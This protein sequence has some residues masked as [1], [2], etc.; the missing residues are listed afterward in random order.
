MNDSL[1]KNPRDISSNSD[2]HNYLLYK[3]DR[4]VIRIPYMVIAERIAVPNKRI[5]GRNK[6]MQV[7]KGIQID[8]TSDYRYLK[9]SQLT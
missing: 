4:S 6:Q 9:G 8:L 5:E 3:T 2:C 1:K 7:P